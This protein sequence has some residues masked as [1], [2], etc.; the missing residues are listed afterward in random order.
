MSK[1]ERVRT[2]RRTNRERSHAELVVEVEALRRENRT[3]MAIVDRHN[4]RCALGW[5]KVRPSAG[6]P[7]CVRC[8]R[9]WVR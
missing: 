7:R 9:W 8:L 4:L 1:G 3:L 6:G 5:H 2:Q